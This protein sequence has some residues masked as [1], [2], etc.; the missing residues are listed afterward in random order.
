L[1]VE[2]EAMKTQ[3]PSLAS[4]I[5]RTDVLRKSLQRLIKR[6]PED[7]LQPDDKIFN[8]I[9]TNDW[10]YLRSDFNGPM[11]KRYAEAVKWVEALHSYHSDLCD[12]LIY[13]LGAPKKVDELPMHPRLPVPASQCLR[14]LELQIQVLTR[15]DREATHSVATDR[16]ARLRADLQAL[17]DERGTKAVEAEVGVNGDTLRDFIRGKTNP[18]EKSLSKYK[19][20]VKREK[21]HK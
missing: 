12:F 10:R 6:Y 3:S 4:F 11:E 2:A 13:S 16:V 15:W 1:S 9:L 8:R 7:A 19:A 17:I 18:H 20:Y 21:S 5:Q 14:C